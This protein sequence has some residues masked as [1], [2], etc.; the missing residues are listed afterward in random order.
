MNLD[1]LNIFVIITKNDQYWSLLKDV[2]MLK[3]YFFFYY[4]KKSYW[5]R[6]L[7]FSIFI[8]TSQFLTIGNCLEDTEKYWEKF[9]TS[10]IVYCYQM[11]Y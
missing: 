11:N 7:F 4:Y 8:K 3:Y 9:D 6:I 2:R 1:Y 5:R 10:L